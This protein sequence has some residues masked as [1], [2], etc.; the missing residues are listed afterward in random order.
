MSTIRFP[1][2]L[3]VFLIAFTKIVI[4]MAISLEARAKKSL[5][6]NRKYI[7][8]IGLFLIFQ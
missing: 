3:R 8:Y 2:I 1:E 5:T 7:N 4:L 6:K